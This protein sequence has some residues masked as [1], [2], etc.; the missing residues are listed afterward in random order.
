MLL[1][2]PTDLTELA[3]SD[4][5]NALVAVLPSVL[6][7][8]VLAIVAVVNRKKQKK[9]LVGRFVDWMVVLMEKASTLTDGIER[10][11][12]NWFPL[13]HILRTPRR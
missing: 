2:Q 10:L 8:T 1:A 5:A 13:P 7:A 9:S 11:V 3:G 6:Y 12:G 4:P